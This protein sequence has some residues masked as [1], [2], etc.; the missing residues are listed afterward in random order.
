MSPD[1]SNFA[2]AVASA[3]VSAERIKMGLIGLV[4]LGFTICPLFFFIKFCCC[5]IM[6]KFDGP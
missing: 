5:E 6:E 3:N 1:L 2:A 4:R